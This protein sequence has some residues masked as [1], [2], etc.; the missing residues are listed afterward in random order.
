MLVKRLFEHDL[1]K[2]GC[3]LYKVHRLVCNYVLTF[4]KLKN[5]YM[6][7]V[8]KVI[9]YSYTFFCNRNIVSS[10]QY[11]ICGITFSNT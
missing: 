5:T 6:T 9:D 1:L 8:I 11:D 7:M 10:Q 3:L 4:E 2:N